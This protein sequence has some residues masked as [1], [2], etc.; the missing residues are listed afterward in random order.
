MAWQTFQQAMAYY[1]TVL[2]LDPTLDSEWMVTAAGCVVI[3]NK[4]F[5]R[6]DDARTGT[7]GDIVRTMITN[8]GK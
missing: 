7:I 5:E 8:F 1:D 4:F 6:D 2:R 3:A